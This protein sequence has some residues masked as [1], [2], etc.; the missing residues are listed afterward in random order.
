MTDAITLTSHRQTG[1]TDI[2]E[3]LGA[4]QDISLR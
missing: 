4:L 1:L 2:R 3:L